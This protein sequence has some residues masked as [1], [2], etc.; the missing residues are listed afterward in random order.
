M[1]NR[2]KPPACTSKTALARNKP[3]RPH[4]SGPKLRK[5][6]LNGAILRP[7]L[8]RLAAH[9]QARDTAENVPDHVCA[10]KR[11][12]L[13][14]YVGQTPALGSLRTCLLGDFRRDIAEQLLLDQAANGVRR[15]NMNLLNLRR[16]VRWNTQ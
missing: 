13:A 12:R 1:L 10:N 5:W 14:A 11:V 15:D 16:G 4:D 8:S 7:R 9:V 3:Q 2:K 6:S